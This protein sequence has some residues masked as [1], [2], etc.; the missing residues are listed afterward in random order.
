MPVIFVRHCYQSL[1]GHT[2]D[3]IQ[4][5]GD[6]DRQ[7]LRS[8]SN[9]TCLVPHTHNTFGD[10]SIS[11]A[12]PHVWNSLHADLRLQTQ[13]SAFKSQLKTILFSL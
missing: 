13:F 4:L 7:N 5:V 3:D 8:A 9:R 12:V 10:R 6:H 1:F 11:V 2:A